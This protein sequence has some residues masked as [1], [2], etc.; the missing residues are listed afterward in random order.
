MT[1]VFTDAVS[2]RR[3]CVVRLQGI[4]FSLV[5]ATALPTFVPNQ[6]DAFDVEF[7][8]N[9]TTEQKAILVGSTILINAVF[10]ES[11]NNHNAGN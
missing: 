4:V 3:Q 9:A 6:Q 2:I 5:H 10:F 7:P 11:N 8:D 1:E